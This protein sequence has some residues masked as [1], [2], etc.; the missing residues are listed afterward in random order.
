MAVSK[1]PGQSKDASETIPSIRTGG[2]IYEIFRLNGDTDNGRIKATR[3]LTNIL[4]F[5][6]GD[7]YE[8]RYFGKSVDS[9]G[10]ITKA[11][12]DR[13]NTLRDSVSV[14]AA[15]ATIESEGWIN[16]SFVKT[17][18]PRYVNPWYVEYRIRPYDITDRHLFLPLGLQNLKFRGCKLNGTSIN[19]NSAETTD[20]GPVVKVTLV[21]QN[22]IVF[23]NNNITTARSNTSGLPVR[24]LT[25]RDF[26]A[27]TGQISKTV[28]PAPQD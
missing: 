11:F 9:N 21:N 22:Q 1:I 8:Y 12:V 18:N 17:E 3:A 20:G 26:S 14:A 5:Y 28:T 23:S 2:A 4:Q 6:Y 10:Y 24:Q 16:I 7:A 27:G 25:S 19:A 15:M 13:Y